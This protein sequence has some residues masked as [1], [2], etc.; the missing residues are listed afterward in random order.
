[1]AKGRAALSRS[2]YP[3]NPELLEYG[4]YAAFQHALAEISRQNPT[5]GNY[6]LFHKVYVRRAN[7]T[8]ASVKP[9]ELDVVAVLG[10]QIVVVSCTFA[11]KHAI[12]KKKGMEAILR[13]RQLGG[14]EARAIVVCSASREAQQLIQAELKEETGHSSLSLEI[15]GKDTWSHL[16]QAFNQYI[17]PVFGWE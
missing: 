14:A 17:R 13:M 12:V 5:R 3:T 10:Y 4:A 11:N 8:D 16:P 9:F 6:K 1:L 7:P 2:K 15:W